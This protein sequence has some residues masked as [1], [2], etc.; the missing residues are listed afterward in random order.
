[1]AVLLVGSIGEGSGVVSWDAAVLPNRKVLVRDNTGALKPQLESTIKVRSAR[2]TERTGEE[3]MPVD[4]LFATV[5]NSYSTMVSCAAVFED[6]AAKD[7]M[8]EAG[9]S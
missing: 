9:I 1:M 8:K 6:A 2:Y 5:Q 7:L 3:H 4:R